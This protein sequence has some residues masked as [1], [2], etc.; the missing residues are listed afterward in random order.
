MTR[1]RKLVYLEADTLPAE[2][3]KELLVEWRKQ[4]NLVVSGLLEYW[5]KASPAQKQSLPWYWEAEDGINPTVLRTLD[6]QVLLRITRIPSGDP[7]LLWALS[8]GTLAELEES[9]RGFRGVG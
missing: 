1:S 8:A 2:E 7:V 4:Q 3:V 9:L 6:G 5:R